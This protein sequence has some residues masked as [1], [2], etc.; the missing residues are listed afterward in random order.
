MLSEARKDKFPNGD[1][2]VP[3]RSILDKFRAMTLWCLDPQVTP[4]QLQTEEKHKSG[5][6]ASFCH[7]V[8]P[9]IQLQA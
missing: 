7:K 5:E 2:M 4:I 1:G 6:E 9:L 3:V 8:G